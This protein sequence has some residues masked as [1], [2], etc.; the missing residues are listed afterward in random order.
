MTTSSNSNCG[1]FPFSNDPFGADNCICSEGMAV[2][3]YNIAEGT[4]VKYHI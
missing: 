2:K 4:V 1:K 3:M